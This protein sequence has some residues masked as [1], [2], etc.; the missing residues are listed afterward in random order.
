MKGVHLEYTIISPLPVGMLPSSP[1][2][3]GHPIDGP[4]IIA[5]I[6]AL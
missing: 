4:V 2:G 3:L 1:K 5:A 6:A